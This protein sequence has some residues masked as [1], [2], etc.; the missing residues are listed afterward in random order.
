[1]EALQ[2]HRGGRRG[3]Q[4]LL[5]RRHYEA[6]ARRRARG[7]RWLLRVPGSYTSAVGLPESGYVWAR[8]S[9]GYNPYHQWLADRGYAVLSVNFRGSTGFGKNYLNAGNR[10]WYGKMQDDLVDAVN[11][12]VKEGVADPDE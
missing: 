1:M 8:D 4:L 10:E 7:R 5:L 6:L 12:A 2:W 11:W 9:W 3:A